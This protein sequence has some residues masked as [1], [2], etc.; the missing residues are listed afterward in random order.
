MT[1]ARSVSNAPVDAAS[2]LYR[3]SAAESAA[4]FRVVALTDRLGVLRNHVN[5]SVGVGGGRSNGRGTPRD[6]VLHLRGAQE[7]LLIFVRAIGDN[8]CREPSETPVV[9]GGGAKGTGP[10]AGMIQV[11]RSPGALGSELR[12]IF[13]QL[14]SHC[15]GTGLEP[16]WEYLK[17]GPFEQTGAPLV[18]GGAPTFVPSPLPEA[19][20][21]LSLTLGY[22]YDGAT[23]AERAAPRGVTPRLARHSLFPTRGGPG[24]IARRLRF[25]TDTLTYRATRRG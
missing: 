3:P 24:R 18:E 5:A 21:A 9:P 23:I 15:P 6:L 25:V 16:L 12:G 7:S 22:L 11:P 8:W 2:G 4:R 1:R 13:H 14:D 20:N 10:V 17:R 19:C